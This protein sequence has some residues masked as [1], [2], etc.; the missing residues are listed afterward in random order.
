MQDRGSFKKPM[1]LGARIKKMEEA[2][3]GSMER[4]FQV[5]A[6]E[7]GE[8][9]EQALERMGIDMEETPADFVFISR[10]SDPE[11]IPAEAPKPPEDKREKARS[12]ISSLKAKGYTGEQ[13]QAMVEGSMEPPV[14]DDE[15]EAAPIMEPPTA[16]P[17]P[18]PSREPFDVQPMRADD[19]A[20]L[21]H[22]RRFRGRR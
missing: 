20:S 17:P 8:S 16:P 3:F 15:H 12:I 22:P 2:I 11:A 14:D 21:F 4:P 18:P 6:L 19:L 5:V 13:I 10:F 1:S 7:Y 9:R